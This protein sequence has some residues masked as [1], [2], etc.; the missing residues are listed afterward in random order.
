MIQKVFGSEQEWW[1][2]DRRPVPSQRIT[3]VF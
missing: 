3:L 2:S 1:V